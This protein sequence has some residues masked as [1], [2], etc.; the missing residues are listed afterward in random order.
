MSINSTTN[1]TTHMKN[2]LFFSIL[3]VCGL[4][5]YAQTPC[6]NGFAGNY[7]CNGYDLLSQIS[8]NVLSGESQQR[9]NDSWGWTDPDSGKEY[10]IVGLSNATAFIDISDPI[11]PIFLGRVETETFPSIWRDI[12]VHGNYAFIVA[13]AADNHGMQVFDLTRLR[14]V[15]NPPVNFTT[16]AHY[17]GIGSCHNIVINPSEPYAYLVGCD[18]FAGGPV[19]VDISNPLNPQ[20]AGGYADSGYTHDAQVVTYNGPDAD[21]TGRQ[22]YVGSN[23]SFGSNNKVVFVDVTNKNNPILISEIDYDNPGYTHQ[24]WLTDDLSY[25][26]LGDELDEQSFGI[27]TRT[28]IFDVQDLDNPVLHNDYFGPTEAIDHNGY[29]LGDKFY[30]ANYTAGLRVVDIADI[31]N[32]N[33]NLEEIGYFDTYPQSNVADFD[34]AW[35]VYPYFESGNIVISDI[36]RGFFLVRPSD[37]T[38]GVQDMNLGTFSIYPNPATSFAKLIAG[39]NAQIESV[40]VY[41]ILGQEIFTQSQINQ[42]EFTLPVTSFSKGVYI[43]KINEGVTKKLVVR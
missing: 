4:I 21:Y 6:E 25:L 23:G 38:M 8:V 9:G 10:A 1:L 7:P 43:V 35:S 17:D 28:I 24:C 5:T 13:D 34:G 37:G 32:S 15:T 41:S 30:L 42:K 26:L 22:I 29:V 40:K 2:N 14:N 12:K 36:S 39:K 19:F 18:D 20:G 11:N 31:E 27:D 33:A 3:M 16:D